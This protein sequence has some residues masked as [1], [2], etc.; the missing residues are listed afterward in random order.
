MIV[1]HIYIIE[2]KR[3]HPSYVAKLQE[4]LNLF[5]DRGKGIKRGWATQAQRDGTL[6]FA[7]RDGKLDSDLHAYYLKRC[8]AQVMRVS[9]SK[10]IIMFPGEPFGA[11]EN[12]N[13]ETDPTTPG[14]NP[15]DNEEQ[16]D[17]EAREAVIEELQKNI[18][19]GY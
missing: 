12:I 9:D 16:V 7:I 14:D 3:T 4:F 18:P 5:S 2:L 11:G 6:E 1:G 15:A 19:S 17:E 10:S 13:K 8:K